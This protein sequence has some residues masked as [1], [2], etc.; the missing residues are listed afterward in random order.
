MRIREMKVR[1]DCGLSVYRRDDAVRMEVMADEAR[2]SA[3]RA[4]FERD[5]GRNDL[6]PIGGLPKSW[7]RAR[8]TNIR[9]FDPKTPGK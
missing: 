9:Y 7:K 3:R 8:A 5:V 1:H 2:A 4:R 6:R